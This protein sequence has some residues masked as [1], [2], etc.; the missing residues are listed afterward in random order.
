MEITR[1][2]TK[3][4]QGHTDA[5]AF[6]QDTVLPPLIE[7]KIVCLAVRGFRDDGTEIHFT[8]V[9]NSG[10]RK[11]NARLLGLV[12]ELQAELVA[13]LSAAR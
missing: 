8:M 2:P 10:E 5:I 13:E 6:F 7:N 4:G 1:L 11:H 9:D 12:A 3:F